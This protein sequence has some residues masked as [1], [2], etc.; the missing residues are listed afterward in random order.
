MS[1]LEGSPLIERA[2]RSNIGINT[3]DARGL[4]PPDLM[5]D[6][7][8][9]PRNSR[10]TIGYKASYRIAAQS[11]QSDILAQF[12]DGTGGTFFHNR[13][14]I[15]EGLREASAAPPMCDLLGFSPEN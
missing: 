7:S 2:T 10:R 5:G 8:A 12:A 3:I 9:P 6:I 15:D 1:S 14:D 4:Y 11:A 13:N